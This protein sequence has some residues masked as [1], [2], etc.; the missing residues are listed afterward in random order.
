M[1]CGLANVAR[2]ARGAWSLTCSHRLDLHHPR[3]G[4]PGIELDGGGIAAVPADG[5]SEREGRD[6][7]SPF[8][9]QRHSDR[10]RIGFRLGLESG[11]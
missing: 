2:H 3:C 7:A 5:E 10:H 1:A 4:Q 8:G 9:G 11:R 6:R